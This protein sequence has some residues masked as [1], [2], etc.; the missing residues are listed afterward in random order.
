MQFGVHALAT[1]DLGHIGA[2]ERADLTISSQRLESTA[3]ASFAMTRTTDDNRLADS[4]TLL[5]TIHQLD[6]G[7]PVRLRLTRPS[8]AGLVRDFLERLSP[9]TRQRRFLSPM[10][11]VPRAAVDHFT[12]YDPRERRVIAASAPG[13]RGEE[14]VGIGDVSLVATGIAEIGLVVDDAH[15]SRGIGKLVA[16]AIASLALSRGA[17]H[18][19]AEMLDSSPAVLRVLGSIGPTISEIEDGRAVAYAK[20]PARTSWAA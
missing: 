5:A 16:E 19:K 14:I 12:F 8:D 17:T 2:G 4:G 1:S 3:P 6:G 9:E 15:Q 18:L 13:E 20:L 11:R 10:P 7:R